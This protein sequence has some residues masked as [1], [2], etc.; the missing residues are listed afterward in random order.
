[1]PSLRDIAHDGKTGSPARP[2]RTK[3]HLPDHSP[4]ASQTGRRVGPA[5]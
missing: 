4:P 2:S 1:M 3:S 5:L